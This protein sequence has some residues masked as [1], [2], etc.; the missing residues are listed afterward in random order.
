[1]IHYAPNRK[2][3]LKLAN[4]TRRRDYR[5]FMRKM[6]SD[7]S[8][9]RGLEKLRANQHL[10]RKQVLQSSH[11]R[12]T[13]RKLRKAHK[14]IFRDKWRKQRSTFMGITQEPYIVKDNQTPHRKWETGARKSDPKQ[15]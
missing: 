6:V 12:N 8:K 3:K 15:Q 13:I 5:R 10:P 7:L 2:D 14:H 1:M 9:K 4:A 11:F